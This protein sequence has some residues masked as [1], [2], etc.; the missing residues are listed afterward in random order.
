[1]M[2]IRHLEKRLRKLE[3]TLQREPNKTF[4]YICALLWF[5]VAYYLGDPSR[6][7]KPFAAFA[8]ALGY[9]NESELKSADNR[10]LLHRLATAQ[11][12]LYD[13]FD[14]NVSDWNSTA[15]ALARMAAGLPKSY[16]DQIEIVLSRAKISL[17]WLRAQTH[18]LAAYINFFA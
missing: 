3:S 12:K 15:E 9:A 7:E 13:K 16:R 2:N 10:D 6:H 4:D 18:D 1:M 5:A 8:R 11:T 14:C 17:R